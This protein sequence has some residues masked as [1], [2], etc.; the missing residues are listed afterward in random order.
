[1]NLPHQPPMRFIDSLTPTGATACFAADHFAV[2][3]GRVVEAA[4]IE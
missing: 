4:L 1:M 3:D 2:S